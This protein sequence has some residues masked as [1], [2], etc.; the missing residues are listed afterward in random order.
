M[1]CR[2]NFRNASAAAGVQDH[3]GLLLPL[4]DWPGF[5][6]NR[7]HRCGIEP[8]LEGG[9]L[10]RGKVDRAENRRE[11]LFVFWSIEKTSGL[12]LGEEGLLSLEGVT[13]RDE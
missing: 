10:M 13:R 3:G 6:W 5:E 9:H 4:L 1:A 11:D 2:N 7:L 12:G 8:F